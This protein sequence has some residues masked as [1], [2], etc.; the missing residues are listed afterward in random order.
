MIPLASLFKTVTANGHFQ[1]QTLA[2]GLP[3]KVSFPISKPPLMT[4]RD[5]SLPELQT[6]STMNCRLRGIQHSPDRLISAGARPIVHKKLREKL[7]GDA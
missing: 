6:G 1:P 2:Y 7:R 4:G 3:G 5:P